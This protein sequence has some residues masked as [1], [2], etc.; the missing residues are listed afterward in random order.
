MPEVSSGVM[1]EALHQQ[2]NYLS[3]KTRCLDWINCVSRMSAACHPC[4]PGA[5]RVSQVLFVSARYYSC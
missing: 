5:I 1:S 3:A 2:K 4:Q